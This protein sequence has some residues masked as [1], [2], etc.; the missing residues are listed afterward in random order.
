MK[1][2]LILQPYVP[3]YRV[4]FFR[5]LRA[6]L[7]D[8]GF[9]LTLAAGHAR[10][11]LAERDDDCTESAA[12]F[13]L[14][15]RSI[16]LKGRTFHIRDVASVLR[17]TQ[18]D[19]VVTEQ[20][21]KNTD[22]YSLLMRQVVKG[23]PRFGLWGQG[24]AFSTRQGRAGSSL[25]QWMTGRSDWF[26]AY[27]QEGADYVVQHGFPSGRVTVVNNTVDTERLRREFNDVDE[28][29][30]DRFRNQHS[31]WPGRTAL[32][33]GGVD[34]AKG[35]DFLLSAA[36]KLEK[37]LPGFRLIIVG[38]GLSSA[39]V[40]RRQT[41]GAPIVYLGR[42]DGSAKALALRAADI[43]MIPEWVGLV[44]VDSLV[45]SCPIAT[46]THNS[47]APEFSYLRDQSNAFVFPHDSEVYAA[48]I[49]EVLN[50]PALMNSVREQALEDSSKVTLAS[51]VG[52]FC[53]GV[54]SWWGQSGGRHS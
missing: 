15:S 22:I 16:E 27:T 23:N 6:S 42:L 2:L 11:H 40:Q 21:I 50:R 3:A 37:R 18:P 5:D 39:Y 35:I 31:L 1:R 9:E 33:I 38:S 46:T 44:A 14:R 20:A 49:A 54:E 8:K 48:G 32:F 12:D 10:G 45:A 26:F 7:S 17:E 53:D 34:P 24:R 52:R 28:V 19:L 51:M 29:E 13:L 4:P 36:D 47:H 25:K 41:E 30:V 43:M